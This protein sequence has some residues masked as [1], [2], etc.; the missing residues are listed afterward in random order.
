MNKYK[1]IQ[2]YPKAT[3]TIFNKERIGLKIQLIDA[4]GTIEP[5]QLPVEGSEVPVYSKFIKKESFYI[6]LIEHTR[7]MY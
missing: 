3:N 1:E 2:T 5:S 4:I 7:M 6:N